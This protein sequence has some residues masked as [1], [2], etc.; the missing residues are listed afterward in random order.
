MQCF[1]ILTAI[2]KS[3]PKVVGYVKKNIYLRKRFRP[4]ETDPICQP[5]YNYPTKHYRTE[6]HD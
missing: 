2:P 3:S 6:V 5:Q 1:D 4:I